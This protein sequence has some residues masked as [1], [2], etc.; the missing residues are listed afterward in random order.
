MSLTSNA[1][2]GDR[3]RVNATTDYY[4]G[5]DNTE[6]GVGSIGIVTTISGGVFEV[7]FTE[8]KLQKLYGPTDT[9]PFYGTELD[10]VGPDEV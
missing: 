8:P 9:W 4:V 1:K 5:P 6:F 3:V 7:S 2:V 10:E